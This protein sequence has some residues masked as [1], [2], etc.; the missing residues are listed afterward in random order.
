MSALPPAPIP[1]MSSAGESA[2]DFLIVAGEEFVPV[3]QDA[4]VEVDATIDLQ[5]QLVES[6]RATLGCGPPLTGDRYRGVAQR[7]SVIAARLTQVA[8]DEPWEGL[9]GVLFAAEIQGL[10]GAVRLIGEV[11]EVVASVL[12]YQAAAV[13]I[14]RDRLAQIEAGLVAAKSD[15]ISLIGSGNLVE[16]AVLQQGAVVHAQH[17]Y[18]MAVRDFCAVSGHHAVYLNNCNMRLVGYLSSSPDAGL[19]TAG[20]ALSEAVGLSPAASEAVSVAPEAL[21]NM[22]GELRSCAFA[23]EQEMFWGQEILREVRTTHGSGGFVPFFDSTLASF[24]DSHDQSVWD[25]YTEGDSHAIRLQGI[26]H[27]Y[28]Q[29]DAAAANELADLRAV[30]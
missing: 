14:T 20:G 15:V 6:A 24:S 19:E 8:A 22:A 30:R 9:S 11:D 29:C 12:D 26:A 7:L 4:A 25:L 23:L 27:R 18:T 2:H 3:E 17:W 10:V 13:Q 1:F 16:A 21:T 5:L 28:Q